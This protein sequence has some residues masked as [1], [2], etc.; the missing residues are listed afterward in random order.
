[1][2]TIGVDVG[3]TFTDIILTSD[4]SSG[5]R[6]HKIP[7]TPS[8]Q[9]EAVVKGILEILAENSV[10][11][12]EIG[13]IVHGTTV[14]TNAMLEGKGASVLLV[15]THGMEDVIEIGRQNREEIYDL[16]ASK[17]PVLVPRGRRV[18]VR[19]R[20][21]PDGEV[22][23]PL[24][25]NEIERLEH[26]VQ[27]TPSDA[28]AVALLFSYQ[29][30][31]HER[32][33]ASQIE[34]LGRYTVCSSEVLPEFREFERT[35]TTVLEAYLGPLVVNYLRKLDS[36]I[37]SV[38]PRAKLAVMQSNGGTV[39]ASNTRGNAVKLA[40]SGLAGGVIGGWAVS[41][42]AGLSRVITLDMGGTSCDI[43]AV[44]DRVRVKADNEVAGL[45]LRTPSVDVK[46]IGAGGGS[47]AWIDALGVLH[48]GPQSAGSVPGPAAYGRGG[49]SATITDANIVLGRIDPDYFLGGRVKLDASLARTAVQQ[50]A[51]R[52]SLSCE[53]AAL[54]VV[55][56]STSNM[57]Q[58]IREVTVERGNDPRDFVLVPFG[59]AGPTQAVDIADALGIKSVLIPPH[60]GITSAFGL[61]CA[62]LRSDR[63]KTV[64]VSSRTG[65]FERVI[66]TLQEL[67]EAVRSSLAAQGVSQ[68]TIRVEWEIDMR[69]VGQSHELTVGVPVIDTGLRETSIRLFTEAHLA[70]YGYVLKDRDIE[71]VT[72]RTTALA[73]RP[74]EALSA[75][76]GVT[77]DSERYRSVVLPPGIATE[78]RVVRRE[79]L[80][81][82]SQTFGPAIVEQPDT[83]VY[84]GPG[85]VAE[86]RHDGCMLMR[87]SAE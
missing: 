26:V 48:V 34:H 30:D 29:N 62:D 71:W 70:Q 27:Q 21:G 52:L 1:M 69:Y 25:Q 17:P 86:Q 14:A 40:I 60:P 51:T 49:T 2:R 13:L 78:A 35:S 57:V 85:W 24:T 46:T 63:M 37:A 39:L 64:L 81:E 15:T 72:V 54:G 75:H 23:E 19:E 47:M 44:S 77:E 33:I 65:D 32:M 74:R 20:I 61:V 4:D 36:A 42:S 87:R 12:E 59:G 50:I 10:A 5:Y 3:G 80:S 18:G 6:V 55:R 31:A 45:P 84:I 56:V 76:R 79:S 58:A 83:T 53:E 41:Q 11:P 38:C 16:G 68:H 66:T 22:I 7:S 8:A 9:E 28:V 73:T 43:S 82:D 67:T